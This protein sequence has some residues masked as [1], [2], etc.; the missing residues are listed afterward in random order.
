MKPATAWS[1]SRASMS[2]VVSDA[3]GS[4]VRVAIHISDGRGHLLKKRALGWQRTG[5]SLHR[6][7]FRCDLPPGVYFVK[8]FATD[9]SGN[10]QSRQTAGKLVVR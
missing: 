2:Y 1:G 9:R 8:A 7:S 6:F 10:P 4:R 3:A 5:P